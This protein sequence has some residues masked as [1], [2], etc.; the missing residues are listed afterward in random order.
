M[1]LGQILKIKTP[2]VIELFDNSHLQGSNP[3]GASVCFVNGEPF[4]RNYRKY[5]LGEE[6]AGDD[7]HSMKEVLT[8]HYSRLREEKLKMPDL[9][10]LDGG[11]TQLRAC[12]DVLKEL[13]LKINCASL[14]KNDKH[15][16][17]GLLSSNEEKKFIEKSSSLFFMLMKMQ[18]EVHRFAISY[19]ISN[20]KKGMTNS[21]F[22]GIKGLGKARIEKI[23]NKYLTYD[24]LKNASVEELCQIIPKEIAV[25]L[26]KKMQNAL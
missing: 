2:Y 1:Q 10:I 6:V 17:D 13:G 12:K 19:H 7:Y 22:D 18:D 16:T 20:R 5:K 9:I 21:I 26:K 3:V 23:N 4:K 11:L 25:A 14:F 24:D 8:R 15:Q